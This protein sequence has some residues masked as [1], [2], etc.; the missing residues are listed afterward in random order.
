[1]NTAT[2]ISS[3]MN[4]KNWEDR[5]VGEFGRLRKPESLVG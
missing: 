5:E 2:M 3:D 4:D 1:M